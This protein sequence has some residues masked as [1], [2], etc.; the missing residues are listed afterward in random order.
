MWSWTN[1]AVVGG[2]DFETDAGGGHARTPVIS[3]N[4]TRLIACVAVAGQHLPVLVRRPVSLLG[5]RKWRSRRCEIGR[6]AGHALGHPEL[7]Y[8]PLQGVPAE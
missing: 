2:Q 4:A 8:V 3:A 1:A 7:V 5:I 6:V